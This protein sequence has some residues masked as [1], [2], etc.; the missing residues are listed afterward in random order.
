V[1][2]TQAG[3]L[4]GLPLYLV[5]DRG[6]HEIRAGSESDCRLGRLDADF[7]CSEMKIHV[8]SVHMRGRA[9]DM[10]TE[11]ASIIAPD[12]VTRAAQQ[13]PYCGEFMTTAVDINGCSRW[14]GVCRTA[15]T[16]SLP[17]VKQVGQQLF[18][19]VS[20]FSVCGKHN[21][22]PALAHS[23]RSLFPCWNRVRNTSI[24]R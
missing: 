22:I 13:Q 15:E 3:A 20:H 8:G 19:F 5:A 4:N 10:I 18:A 24:R 1:S 6:A 9:S 12:D 17:S 14:R 21:S 11:Q 23:P 16:V 7:L 2:F